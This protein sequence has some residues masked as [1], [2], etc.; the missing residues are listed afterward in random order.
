MLQYGNALTKGCLYRSE[1]KHQHVM[2]FPRQ[3]TAD[4]QF[5]L[6]HVFLS[7]MICVNIN[8]R[9]FIVTKS[10]VS[11]GRSGGSKFI[12]KLKLGDKK[13]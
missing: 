13:C 11:Y 9:K 7:L 6:L 2:Y 3:L 5:R 8:F 4:G 10:K 12:K 1:L